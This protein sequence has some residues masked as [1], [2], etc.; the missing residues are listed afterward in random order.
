RIP[1][2]AV[3]AVVPQ[4]QVLVIDRRRHVMPDR[5]RDLSLRF[6]WSTH[7]LWRVLVVGVGLLASFTVELVQ[8]G[9]R[10]WIKGSPVV[11]RT[12]RR[13]GGGGGRLGRVGPWAC[14]W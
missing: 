9:R 5:Q 1:T 7:V 8:L 6:R 11:A 13:G 2:S 14:G 4:E 12:S 3:I 10:A